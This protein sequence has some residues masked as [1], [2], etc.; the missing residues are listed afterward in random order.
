MKRSKDKAG[1]IHV[2]V[3]GRLIP[4][5]RYVIEKDIG[6]RLTRQEHIHHI[7]GIRDDNRLENLCL[8][9]AQEHI[10]IHNYWKRHHVTQVIGGKFQC[11]K[12]DRILPIEKAYCDFKCGNICK[13]CR[14]K[15]KRF[16]DEMRAT[17][18]FKGADIFVMCCNCG[19]KRKV[20]RINT[21]SKWVYFW[22]P[23][24]KYKPKHKILE[25]YGLVGDNIV[26]EDSVSVTAKGKPENSTVSGQNFVAT[27][28]SE[29]DVLIGNTS[30]IPSKPD[31]NLCKHGVSY[32]VCQKC[33]VNY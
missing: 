26:S 29:R 23:I 21:N 10:K 18:L 32:D 5:H 33:G 30:P 11:I 27:R 12:C 2:W 17:H 14:N 20:V 15:R 13:E 7:N 22:C 9:S 16:K 25:T 3:E 6:R 31:I 1:Y 28:K 4:E 8:L 24:C 19:N